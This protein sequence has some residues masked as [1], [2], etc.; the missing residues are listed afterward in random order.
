MGKEAA[1]SKKVFCGMSFTA[2]PE[3]VS[4]VV[5]EIKAMEAENERLKAEV[6]ALEKVAS[7]ARRLLNHPTDTD[8]MGGTILFKDLA[9]G[10]P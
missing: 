6:L 2:P 3:E 9:G 7:W 4:R 1:L 10:Q 8:G 5:R